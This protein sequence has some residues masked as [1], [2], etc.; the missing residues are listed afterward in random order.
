MSEHIWQIYEDKTLNNQEII[1]LTINVNKWIRCSIRKSA[2]RDVKFVSDVTFHK[3]GEIDVEEMCDFRWTEWYDCV[4]DNVE[5]KYS[6]FS[7]GKFKNTKFENCNFTGSCFVNATLSGIVFNK[8]NFMEA[9][10][11]RANLTRAKFIDCALDGAYFAD[12]VF[13]NTEMS[14]WN[15][16]LIVNPVEAR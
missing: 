9:D 4:L 7:V 1:N 8:C 2:L 14:I 10:F 3:D 11:R 15:N 16:R 5:A 6:D 13:G 12:A